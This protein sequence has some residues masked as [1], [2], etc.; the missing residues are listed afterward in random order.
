MT[1]WNKVTVKKHVDFLFWVGA[2][3]LGQDVIE[4]INIQVNGK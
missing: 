3:N 2:T 1:V 4:D